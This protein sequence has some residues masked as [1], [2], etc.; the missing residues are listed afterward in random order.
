MN[1]I[2]SRIRIR[3]SNAPCVDVNV[4]NKRG[5]DDCDEKAD[6]GSPVEE[7]RE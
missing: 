7:L 4:T 6:T 1:E 2:L 3:E 5:C